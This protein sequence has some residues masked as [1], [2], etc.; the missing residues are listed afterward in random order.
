M[1]YN[2]LEKKESRGSIQSM[3]SFNMNVAG[4]IYYKNADTSVMNRL[5]QRS[6]FENPTVTSNKQ[7]LSQSSQSPTPMNNHIVDSEMHGK[8]SHNKY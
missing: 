2:Q 5:H 6:G 3:S 1:K 8:I 7:P 4:L